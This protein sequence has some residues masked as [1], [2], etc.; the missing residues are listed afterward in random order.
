MKSLLLILFSLTL[1]TALW[2]Q[3]D[4]P[5]CTTCVQLTDAT[6]TEQLNCDLG[7]DCTSTYFAVPCDGTYKLRA[8][9]YCTSVGCQYCVACIH[10]YDGTQWI[11]SVHTPCNSTCTVENNVVLEEGIRYTLYVCL[12]SCASSN[13]L[14]RCTTCTARGRVQYQNSICPAW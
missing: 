6:C 7:E 12:R 13:C 1:C 8:E 9:M 11:A 3:G 2:A 14:D 5:D 4:A 10:I